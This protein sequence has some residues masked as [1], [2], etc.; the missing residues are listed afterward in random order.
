M[1]LLFKQRLFSWFDSYDIYDE[2]GNTVYTVEGKLSWGHKL[3]ILDSR[4]NHIAT[5]KEVV[6]R[7]LSEY[8]LYVG[9]NCIGS[10][11]KQLTF[12]RSSYALNFNGWSVNGNYFGWD[13]G[14]YD[15]SGRQIASVSKELFRFTDTYVIDVADPRDALYVLMITLAIDADKCRQSND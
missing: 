1:K 8:E 13:Y 9:G 15:G 11:K 14:V 12:F 7:F 6:F 4:G 2:G 10:I 5:V 3:H